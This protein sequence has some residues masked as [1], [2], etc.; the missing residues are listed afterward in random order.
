MRIHRHLAIG[1][2]LLLAAVLIGCTGSKP[3][4]KRAAKLDAAGLHAEAAEMYLGSV[5]RNQRNVDAKIGLKKTGQQVLNDK[6]GQFFR[7]MA[8][9]GDRGRIVDAYLDAIAYRD[10]VQRVGVALD[11]PDHY[12][13]DYERVKGEY[14]LELYEE[15]QAMMDKEDFAGAK[16]VFARIGQLDRN[17][18]DAGNLEEVAFLEPRYRAGKHELEAGRFRAAYKEFDLVLQKNPSY[19]DASALRQEAVTRGQYPVAIMPFTSAVKRTELA[20]QVQLHGM[21]AIT[22]LRDP[23]IRVV[24]RENFDR[25]LEEQRLA[26]SGVVDDATAVRVGNLIGAKAVLF[27]DVVDYREV[28][29]EVKRSTKMG[30]ESFLEQQVNKETGE[31]YMVT[32]YRP[33]RYNEVFQENKV[34]LTFSYRLVS[35]ET[36]EVLTQNVLQ[37]EV[38][39][40]MYY[41]TYEGNAER[42]FPAR[43]N[44]VDLNDRARR[45]LRALLAAPRTIKSVATLSGEVVSAVGNNMAAAVQAEINSR[46]P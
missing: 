23:F 32:K 9:N 42:L 25:I 3:M 13:A 28:P 29:G 11:V 15:G 22:Q 39:D 45:D 24:D 31:K 6:L 1:T 33:V 27:G 40:H 19:K 2:A 7:A 36:G 16:R 46:L 43:N 30:F 18:K 21:T 44:A 26:L 12:T 5:Q 34:F 17:F 38:G 37:R 20:R 8:T 14:L 4:A 35:M 41:A 10:R